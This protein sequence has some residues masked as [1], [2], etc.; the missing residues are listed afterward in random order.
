MYSV[1]NVMYMYIIYCTVHN[2][3]YNVHHV[4]YSVYYVMYT[5][6]CT[7]GHMYTYIYIYIYMQSLSS[8][9]SG[10]HSLLLHHW[11]SSSLLLN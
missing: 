10:L 7:H 11:V 4:M 8:F 5:V 3:L 1:H 9:L 2:V 6:W